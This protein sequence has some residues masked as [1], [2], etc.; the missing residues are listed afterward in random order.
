MLLQVIFINCIVKIN[1]KTLTLESYC[2]YV[3]HCIHIFSPKKNLA[4]F[5]ELFNVSRNKYNVGRERCPWKRIVTL[6]I[7]TDFKMWNIFERLTQS[8]HLMSVKYNHKLTFYF[9]KIFIYFYL[10]WLN[11]KQF[12][13]LIEPV[14][15]ETTTKS[16][17]NSVQRELL[18]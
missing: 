16:T 7:F 1:V 10:S 14:W 3:T 13:L 6:Q 12:L 17:M 4:F 18:D 15:I 9:K 2:A 5:F 8:T 11:N